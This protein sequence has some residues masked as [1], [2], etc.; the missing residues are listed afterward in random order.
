MSGMDERRAHV[1]PPAVILLLLLM[2]VLVTGAAAQESG[3]VTRGRSFT[4]TV[5]GDL[6]TPYVVWVSGTSEMSG[7]PGDQ[8]PV[9]APG[10]TDVTTDPPG[11]P[12]PIGSTSIGGSRTVL[13]DV[14]PSS[15]GVPNTS[16]YAQVRTG[17]NGRGVVLFLTS[18]AT[19]TQ[20]FHVAAVNPA[21]PDRE[22]TVILG[23]PPPVTTP[24]VQVSLPPAA[25]PTVSVPPDH[26][27]VIPATIP[28][29]PVLTTAT[30]SPVTPAGTAPPVQPT[31]STPVAA[32]LGILALGMVLIATAGFR[33]RQK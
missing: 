32:H 18:H 2:H 7:E 12:Y 5:T 6:R 27:L 14:A 30:G 15:P 4:V 24:T 26:I 8:P 3:S 13:D 25:S 31:Q 23:V 29:Q 28:E 33:M 9:V 22:V 19:A 1:V 20:Q 11:G 21:D 16:Y 17:I 10:Q